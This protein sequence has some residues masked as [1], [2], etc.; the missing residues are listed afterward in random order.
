MRY[1]YYVTQHDKFNQ[2]VITTVWFTGITATEEAK[3]LT[4][5][6]WIKFIGITRCP[7][8]TAQHT[9]W[10]VVWLDRKTSKVRTS[11]RKGLIK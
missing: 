5:I 11:Q 9:P 3:S 7:K 8:D 4:E 6:P 10:K 2:A 1:D